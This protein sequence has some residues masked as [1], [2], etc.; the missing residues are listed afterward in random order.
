MR[1]AR[2]LSFI[3]TSDFDVHPRTWNISTH[4]STSQSRIANGTAENGNI[5][6]GVAQS[7]SLIVATYDD[8]HQTP[9]HKYIYYESLTSTMDTGENNKT[10]G[11]EHGTFHHSEL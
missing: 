5:I 1:L 6:A 3:G 7:K 8:S 10:E 2:V 11:V 9:F 4:L